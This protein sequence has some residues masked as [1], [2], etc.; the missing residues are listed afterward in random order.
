MVVMRT[1][2]HPPEVARPGKITAKKLFKKPNATR[3]SDSDF[4]IDTIK[5]KG[6]QKKLRIPR[7]D[8]KK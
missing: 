4:T 8:L 1:Q 7:K 5:K 2:M 3:D 6:I